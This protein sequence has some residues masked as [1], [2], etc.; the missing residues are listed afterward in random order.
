MFGFFD[1]LSVILTKVCYF[2]AN[3]FDG[4]KLL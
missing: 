4:I 2:T 3:L 1:M